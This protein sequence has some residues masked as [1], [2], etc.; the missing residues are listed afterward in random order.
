MIIF[1]CCFLVSLKAFIVYPML[2]IGVIFGLWLVLTSFCFSDVPFLKV[3]VLIL[4]RKDLRF[5]LPAA[6]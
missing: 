5:P 6:L 3:H 2:L 4:I 1:F